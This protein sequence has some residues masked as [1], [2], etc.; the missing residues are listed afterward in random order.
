VTAFVS[1]VRPGS[2]VYDIGANVGYFTLAACAAGASLVVALEPLAENASR[3]R[4]HVRLN[5]LESRVN[6]IEAA[7]SDVDGW[8]KW[9]GSGSQ[10]HLQADGQAQVR[11]VRL[12]Q[13]G[14]P[15]P[16]V[17]KIDVEGAAG[18]VL[19]GM[20]GLFAQ[21]RPPLMI[22]LHGGAEGEAVRAVVIPLG[23]EIAGKA[24]DAV[25]YRVP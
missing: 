12:D 18:L 13:H 16:D 25:I 19:H 23:Y 15:A 1:F 11:T 3:L 8:A 17:V 9:S 5:R 21:Y 20:Q 24:G 7:A 10:G 14:L 2:V 22:E 4:E 6:L